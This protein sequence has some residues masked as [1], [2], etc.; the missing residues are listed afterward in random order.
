MY[1]SAMH[2]RVCWFELRVRDIV[3]I[4]GLSSGSCGSC[5]DLHEDPKLYFSPELTKL[6]RRARLIYA[7][8]EVQGC[9]QEN[10]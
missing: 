5:R 1:A 4:V 6:D 9:T 3:V 7:Q 2:G 8:E 10:I